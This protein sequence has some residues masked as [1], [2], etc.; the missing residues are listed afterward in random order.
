MVKYRLWAFGLAIA[1]LLVCFVTFVLIRSRIIMERTFATSDGTVIITV[2]R[3]QE[4]V[5]FDARST[6][7]SFGRIYAR[8]HQYQPNA[9]SEIIEQG[10]SVIV[11]YGDMQAKFEL[12]HPDGFS[13]SRASPK[14]TYPSE[15]EQ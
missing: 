10:S 9:T 6:G 12:V 5:F 4:E 15:S 14:V 13:L 11:R 8:L 1:M 3:D 2:F 7:S